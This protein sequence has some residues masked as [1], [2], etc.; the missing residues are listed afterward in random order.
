[1]LKEFAKKIAGTDKIKFVPA[2][3]PFTEPSVQAM[4][5]H[6][7]LNKWIEA[8]PGGIFRP[9]VTAPFGIKVPVLAWGI[10]IDRLFMIR[11]GITDIRQLFSQDIEYLR[12]A[13]I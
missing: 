5:F 3:F 7:K 10:G 9:E 1:L 11:E 2:Y 4:I 8:M 13:K 6:P 12:E